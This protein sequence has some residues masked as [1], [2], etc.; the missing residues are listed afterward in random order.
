MMT[1][2]S[3]DLE[4][5]VANALQ[6]MAFVFAEPVSSTAGEVLALAAACASIDLRG[7]SNFVVTVTATEGL[8]Q[9]VA[10]GMMGCEPEEIDVDDHGR[11]T[12]LELANIFGGEL[13]MQLASENDTLL[14]GLPRDVSIEDAGRHSDQAQ[15]TGLCCVVGSDSGQLLVTVAGE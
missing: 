9:E 10:S 6:R 5:I 3:I 2:K 11:A 14:I 15:Q 8:V 7:P 13:V 12:V 1:V 4:G